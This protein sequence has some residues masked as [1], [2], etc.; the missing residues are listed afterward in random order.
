MELI[1]KELSTSQKE[2][3]FFCTLVQGMEILIQWHQVMSKAAA[4]LLEQLISEPLAA[5]F[6]TLI[7]L[8]QE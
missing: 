3:L 5:T 8:N 6:M 4:N 7:R 1:L 2:Q